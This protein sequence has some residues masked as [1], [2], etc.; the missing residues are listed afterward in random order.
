MK[1]SELLNENSLIIERLKQ[2]PA[3]KSFQDKDIK[4]LMQFS[5]VKEFQPGEV[6]IREGDTDRG[7][8]FLLSGKVKVI[9]DGVDLCYLGRSGDAFGEMAVVERRPRSATVEAVNTSLTFALDASYLGMLEE[10]DRT[11]FM[12]VIYRIFSELMAARLRDTTN[13]LVEAKKEIARLN[14]KGSPAS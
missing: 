13:E 14:G 10:D 11:V 7:I 1:E 5:K 6:I 4:G 3:F 8:Y 9:K 12:Y 2:L